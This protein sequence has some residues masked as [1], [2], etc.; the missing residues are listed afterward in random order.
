[1]RAGSIHADA[2]RKAS[3]TANVAHT[4]FPVPVSD[5]N[6][7]SFLFD[8]LLS[9]IIDLDSS[10]RVSSHTFGDQHIPEDARRCRRPGD[11]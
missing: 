10:A 5:R 7:A 4:A 2:P 1:M 11:K 3:V 9:Y 8:R 6:A